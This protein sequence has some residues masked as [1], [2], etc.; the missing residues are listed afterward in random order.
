[1]PL[2][3]K[4]MSAEKFPEFIKEQMSKVLMSNDEF[5]DYMTMWDYSSKKQFTNKKPADQNE[6]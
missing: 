3:Q 4:P 2:P 1:M 5:L 6:S